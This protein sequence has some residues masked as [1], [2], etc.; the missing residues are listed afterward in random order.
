MAESIIPDWGKFIELLKL[1]ELAATESCR[2]ASAYAIGKVRLAFE[3]CIQNDTPTPITND[4]S[5][6]SGHLPPKTR[7]QEVAC[8]IQAIVRAELGFG[9]TDESKLASLI[10]TEIARAKQD[11]HQVWQDYT[12]A[13]ALVGRKSGQSLSNAILSFR[14]T[15]DQQVIENLLAKLQHDTDKHREEIKQAQAKAYDLG[16]AEQREA[17][18]K[19][20][21]EVSEEYWTSSENEMSTSA[22]HVAERIRGPL[23]GPN[24]PVAQA[25]KII[26]QMKPDLS[27]PGPAL[28][29]EVAREVMEG[30]VPNPAWSPSTNLMAAMDVV[31]NLKS[32]GFSCA[33]RIGKINERRKAAAFMNGNDPAVESVAETLPL[34]ICLAALKAV[35]K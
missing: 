15:G 32:V 7:G 22:G 30:P 13:A 14:P 9:L 11:R 25:S 27:I 1:G 2:E 4:E 23:Y 28:D 26:R 35:A 18:A 21:D 16:R 6:S 10:D 3:S 17:D 31:E 34:A 20:A 33:M 24:G 12:D 19:I 8:E 5:D 29:E